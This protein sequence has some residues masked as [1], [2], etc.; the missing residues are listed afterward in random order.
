MDLNLKFLDLS[1]FEIFLPEFF[2]LK[3]FKFWVEGFFKQPFYLLLTAFLIS[4]FCSGGILPFQSAN[5]QFYILR[6]GFFAI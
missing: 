2:Q 3:K 6:Q 5:H 1:G 4:L